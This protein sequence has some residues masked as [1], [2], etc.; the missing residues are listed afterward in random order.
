MR[1]H[2]AI[3]IIIAVLLTTTLA[4]LDFGPEEE[5]TAPTASQVSRCRAEMYVRDPVTI[6]PLGFKLD[7][8]GIDDIIWFKFETD[9][10]DLAQVF[11]TT[12]VDVHTF[13]EGVSMMTLDNVAWW[14]VEGK[15]LLGGQVAL[16]NARF[17]TVGA[18]KVEGGYVIYVVWNET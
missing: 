11:D 12:V 13:E 18:E 1:E 7:G 17:M 16:P 5:T 2:Y 15:D 6:T 8:S 9:S 4:C 14:D 10:D 3:V